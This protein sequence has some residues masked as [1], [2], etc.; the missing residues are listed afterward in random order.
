MAA[1]YM[2]VT[3]YDADGGGDRA[4]EILESAI[5]KSLP[6]YKTIASTRWI[7]ISSRQAISSP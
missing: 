5:W 1:D 3:V 2:F 4:K 6:A 7:S